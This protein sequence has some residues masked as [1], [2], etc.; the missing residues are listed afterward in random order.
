MLKEVHIKLEDSNIANYGSKD[1]KD[2]KTASAKTEE[3]W[4]G[5]GQ[6]PGV[7]IWRI[8]K[9]KVVPWPKDQYGSFYTGDAYIVL[10]TYKAEGK[11]ALRYNIH[12]WL[13]SECSQD[14]QGTAAYK[15]VELD[16]LFGDLPVQ[17][18]EVQGSESPEFLALFKT[19]HLLKGG[20]ESGFNKVKPTEY[21]A[22]LLHIKG[23]KDHV[24]ISEVNLEWKSLN[25]GDVFVLDA[26]LEVYTWNGP[27][28]GIFEKRK[29][30][31]VVNDIR[32]KRQ[33]K[34]KCT[35][36]DGLED[37]E[38][39]WKLLGGKPTKEQL[40][41]ET[42]DDD[43]Q[44]VLVKSLWRLS[45]ATGDLKLSEVASGSFKKNQLDGSDVFLIDTGDTLFV[46]VGKGTSK[47]EKANAIPYGSLYLKH[48]GRPYG[49]PVSRVTEG[50]EPPSFWKHFS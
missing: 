36:L 10:H 31:D 38:A 2:L 42:P 48:H 39:F 26:G 16:D 3:A 30:Q 40:P 12:F 23:V 11:D 28:G 4:K 43:K 9:F 21:K 14:E 50:A 7:E 20:I 1:H 44:K 41:K 49:T 6:K 29:A 45:D 5:C 27:K 25:A 32:E 46:W 8:E 13:G 35:I 22:K 18:R 19:I 17:Y 24:R 37:D 33:G 15:T 47:K 34:P